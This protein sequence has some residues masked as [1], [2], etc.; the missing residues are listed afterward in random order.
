MGAFLFF[1]H[2]LTSVKS[3]LEQLIIFLIF[4]KFDKIVIPMIGKDGRFCLLF[5]PIRNY[6]E[7]EWGEQ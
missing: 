5:S 7:K 4:K 2:R 6:R 1:P 3:T